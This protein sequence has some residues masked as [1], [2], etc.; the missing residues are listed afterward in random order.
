MYTS[1]MSYQ[2]LTAITHDNY[3]EAET[4]AGLNIQAFSSSLP[5]LNDKAIR[6]AVDPDNNANPIVYQL[7][8]ILAHSDAAQLSH[9]VVG[10]WMEWSLGES[11]TEFVQEL[12]KAA[13]KLPN[14]KGIFIGD[15]TAYE[16]ELSWLN[17][18]D[19][20]PLLEA[21]PDLEI[22][23][24]R[25]MGA[26]IEHGVRH[27]HL[28]HLC[29]ETIDQLHNNHSS[30]DMVESVCN[31]SF[32]ALRHLE[33][34]QHSSY[35]QQVISRNSFPHLQYLG[36]RNLPE[37]DHFVSNVIAPADYACNAKVLDI[38]GGSLQ[39]AGAEKLLQ[40]HS[41]MAHLDEIHLGRPRLSSDFG[42][43]FSTHNVELVIND[44]DYDDVIA[45]ETNEY[46]MI[47][48]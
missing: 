16:V 18:G 13:P 19:L 47:S 36:I 11:S 24:V 8:D 31:G 28:Q 23:Q 9:L 21:Y 10:R 25:G 20:T 37:L 38:S 40:N 35:W 14:L 6:I 45:N 32:P 44:N 17:H 43:E 48:E 3:S 5:T 7:D 1:P 12:A 42:H 34:W 39:D 46:Q 33:I 4:F 2:P 15:V 41:L 30:N 29:Y 22:L 26:S 27:H